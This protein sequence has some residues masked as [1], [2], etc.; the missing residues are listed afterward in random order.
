MLCAMNER[1][2][3]I[4]MRVP[5]V[6]LPREGVD[7]QKWAVIACDQYTSEPEYWDSVESIVG[8]APSTLRLTLPERYLEEPD[9]EERVDAI[10]SSM[11]S[12]LSEK[13]VRS[14][15]EGFVLV[16]RVTGDGRVRTGLLAAID[17]DAYDY[18][19]TSRSLI[20]ATEGTIAE[21]IPPR[22]RVRRRAPLELPHVLVLYDDPDHSVLAGIS[23]DPAALRPLYDFDL[24]KSA[25]RITASLIADEH[26]V[27]SILKGFERLAEPR[28]FAERHGNGDVL[29]F[30]VGDGNHSLAAAK[31]VWDELKENGADPEQ[32]PGRYALVELVNIHDE[33]IHFEAI[34]RVLF[35]AGD[36]FANELDRDPA[37]TLPSMISR[38][39]SRWSWTKAAASGSGLPTRGDFALRPSRDLRQTSRPAVFNR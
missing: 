13:I 9:V 3:A 20:R 16:R 15:D 7:Y 37:M 31:A 18:S 23:R 10:I 39:C 26:S 22:T 36:R 1:F 28:L 33:G 35:G 24:M 11:D 4:G 25:G 30:A 21:R 29:L 34:H 27:E 6:Y 2:A 19:P 14:V 32:H 5:Q 17:L 38:R 12:Y 8:E